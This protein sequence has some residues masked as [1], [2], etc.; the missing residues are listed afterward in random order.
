MSLPVAA[1][2]ERSSERLLLLL[3]MAL[4]F[5]L[6]ADIVAI[7]TGPTESNLILGRELAKRPGL[8]D[9]RRRPALAGC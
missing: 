5:E 8:A 2:I 9:R 4:E 3:A 7:P 6:A 1:W